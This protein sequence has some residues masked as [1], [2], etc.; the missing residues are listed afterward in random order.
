MA[1]YKRWF[2][3]AILVLGMVG[4]WVDA[5]GL[6]GSSQGGALNETG[7]QKYELQ[8][9]SLWVS[10]GDAT[11]IFLPNGEVALVDTGQDFAVRDYVLPFLQRHGIDRLDYLILTHYDGDH[12]SGKIE[13][14]GQT[15]LGSQWNTSGPRVPVRT[16]WDYNTFR[17]GDHGNWGGVELLV[18]NSAHENPDGGENQK[19]LSLHLSYNGFSYALGGDIYREQQERI[20]RDFP[21][22]FP[23]HVYRTNHH[24]HGSVSREYLVRSNP[25]LFITSAEEAVYERSAYVDD[26]AAAVQQLHETSDRHAESMLT[27][28]DGNIV[29]AANDGGDWTYANFPYEQRIRGLGAHRSGGPEGPAPVI[30]PATPSDDADAPQPE[31]SVTTPPAPEPDVPVEQAPVYPVCVKPAL[32]GTMFRYRY[33]SFD[34]NW[35]YM[36]HEYGGGVSC[37]RDE[38]V[39]G[40]EY[41]V[42][43]TACPELVQRNGDWGW[44]ENLG[45]FSCM[46]P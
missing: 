40:S 20:L 45:G 11:L 42:C 10:H 38:D 31:P 3:L 39:E 15:Y 23:V 8:I 43:H 46:E 5:S 22:T 7:L 35:G 4:C 29:V 36:A 44:C 30:E 34:E 17:A 24:M 6:G 13:V 25:Y 33:M 19:S 26:L 2:A 1:W 21:E 37:R 28:E 9:V 14:G 41:P 12:A 32:Q 27:L 18:L 16:V